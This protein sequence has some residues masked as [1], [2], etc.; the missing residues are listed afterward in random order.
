LKHSERRTSYD[1]DKDK[2]RI[3]WKETKKGITVSLPQV[4]TK[5]EQRGEEAID[6]LVNHVEE[7]LTMMIQ[8]YTLAGM[9]K[10]IY[11]VIRSTS[12]PTKTNEDKALVTKEHTAETRIF[13]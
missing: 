10:H 2:F 7:A 9:E 5:Y 3:E 4:I 8:T 1:R 11:P 13:Y 12:F 6:E